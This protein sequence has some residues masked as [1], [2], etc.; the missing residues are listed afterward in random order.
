MVS[1]GKK[2]QNK[3][4]K[5]RK[6]DRVS[7]KTEFSALGDLVR[8]SNKVFIE[9]QSLFFLPTERRHGGMTEI[10]D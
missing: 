3:K 7:R 10:C 2:K 1:I 5:E 8:S 9:S 4:Q 6:K